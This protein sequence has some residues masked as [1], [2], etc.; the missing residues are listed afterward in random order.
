MTDNTFYSSLFYLREY[1]FPSGCGGCGEALVNAEEAYYG[2]CG[3]CRT[4]FAAALRE[5]RHRR[6]GDLPK[7]FSALFPYT[8]KF[9]VILGAYKFGKALGLGNFFV[10]CLKDALGDFD[11]EE[12]RKAAWVPVPPRPGKIRKQGW[13][14]IDY[15]AM[16][17]ERDSRRGGKNHSL[18]VCRCLKRLP[19]RSQKELNRDERKSN[20]KGHILCSK[21]TPETAVIFDDV[22]TT[23]TTMEA[24]AGALLDKGARRI[25]G[26]CLFYD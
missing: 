15:L 13:D 19:S 4:F 9:R 5:E 1:F 8:G 17:L 18:P 6:T 21:P 3:R 16:L 11:P 25:Y 12:I 24:C 14:Q 20:L 22:V 10:H 23:G 2:L 26:V 7:K